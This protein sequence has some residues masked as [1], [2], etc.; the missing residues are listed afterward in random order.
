MNKAA[1]ITLGC[2]VNQVESNSIIQ[3]LID[4]G[5]E[6]VEFSNAADIYIINTCTVTG[7]ADY[8]SRNLIRHALKE[9]SNNPGVKVIVTG[10]YSQKEIREVKALGDIDLIV[11]NFNKIDLDKWF[12]AKNYTF[13]EI[14]DFN[15]MKWRN[16]QGIYDKTRAFIKVQ[17]G[18]DYFCSYCA[19]PL[20]RGK[21]RSLPL[22]EVIKQAA[23]LID[24]GFREI[25]IT[26]VN[27]GLYCDPLTNKG[28]TDLIKV[29]VNLDSSIL[30][31]LS[32]IEPN[33]WNNDFLELMSQ[34]SNIC[35]HF[36]IP[37]Q[38]GSNKV[39]SLMKRQYEIEYVVELVNKL[40]KI[41]P[42]CAIGFDIICGFPGET[43]KE[44]LKTKQI[45]ET[46]PI[47]YLHVFGYSTRKSTAAALR[48][49]DNTKT[50]IADRVKIIN[51]IGNKKKDDYILK[52][53][54]EKVVLK[55]LIEKAT[56]SEFT[57]L[58][59]HYIRIYGKGSKIV[60]DKVE[61]VAEA[62]FKDGI[63]I[64]V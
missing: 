28:L 26:G 61:G 31:R 36:H 3:Q 29:M 27:L 38:S 15:H 22:K 9:K 54:S 55:G 44:F 49:N 4:R 40:S 64:E 11:D 34:Y 47:A 18:C 57:S 51:Q 41:K 10:C 46:L 39:L 45:V 42:Y 13:A 21:P 2:K 48:H 14:S 20:G 56:S 12:E 16:V 33:L 62:K 17:D 35:P 1:I 8:K 7:R 30:I 5:Y 60:G 19:V 52:L 6:I 63:L 24:A 37:V 53:I 32:S 50:Q 25:V 43:E 23:Y 59:D 58:S